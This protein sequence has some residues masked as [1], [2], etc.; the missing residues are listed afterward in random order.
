MMRARMQADALYAIRDSSKFEFGN[1]GTTVWSGRSP[2]VEG[3]PT[4]DSMMKLATLALIA[5]IAVPVA[6]Y[7]DSSQPNSAP[8][9]EG[10]PVTTQG[11]G[12]TGMNEGAYPGTAGVRSTT[13]SAVH[14]R[15]R[16]NDKAR[17]SDNPGM[18]APDSLRR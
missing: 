14:T 7:A 5:T 16:H 10:R 1:F 9:L 2:S 4:G 15:T 12:T 6:A 11:E 13:G 8:G 3:S 17:P 18:A